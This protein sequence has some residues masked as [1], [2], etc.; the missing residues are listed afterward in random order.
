M[1]PAA[2]AKTFPPGMHTMV[3]LKAGSRFHGAPQLQAAKKG[4]WGLPSGSWAG[5]AQQ[6]TFA[7]GGRICIAHGAT[8]L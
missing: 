3:L 2:L 5:S 8:G 1:A 6:S 4:S 7:K